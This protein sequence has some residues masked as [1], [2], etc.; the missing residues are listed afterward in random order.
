MPRSAVR[1]ELLATAALAAPLVLTQLTQMSMS[2]IDV[3]MVGRLGTAAM[4]AAVIGS[5]VYMTAMMVCLG[6]VVAVQPVVAQA[7]G[8]GDRAA[9]SR[10]VRQGL[11]LSV[12]LGA[13]FVVLLGHTEPLLRALGQAP[14]T[15]ETAARYLAAIRWG[16]VPN[17][18][19]TA[20]RGLSEGIGRPRPVLAVTLLG[21]AMNAGLNAVLIFGLFGAPAMGLVGAGWGVC[22]RHPRDDGRAGGVHLLGA[23]ARATASSAG[24]AGRT[25]RRCSSCSASAGPSA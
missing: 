18:W 11:W 15:A 8:A 19:F 13:P 1:R 23:A 16:F 3:V 9:A 7:T 12:L 6:V 21:V 25:P 20:L 5:T 14:E 22:H 4:A 10:A 2:F 17:L 24:S